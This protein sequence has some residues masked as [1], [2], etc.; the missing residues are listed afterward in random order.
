M[1]LHSKP[2]KR[3]IRRHD[4][5]SVSSE[6]WRAVLAMRVDPASDPLVALWAWKGW[7]L[8][9]RRNLPGEMHG[10][11]L[12]LPLPPF[13]GKRRISFHIQHEHIVSI[14]LPPSLNSVSQVAPR[15]WRPTLNRLA[16]LESRHSV[17]VRVFGSLA[18][19]VLTG[20]DYLT[21]DSD[22]DLLW[23]VHGDTDLDH[24]TADLAGIEAV[25]PMRLDGELVCEDGTAVNWREFH[26]GIK[27][28]L[29][30][31]VGGVALL[32]KT[33]FLPRK[34]PS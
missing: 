1:T 25:A 11:A 7:P 33:C 10:V 6:G 17:D 32:D 15:S 28:I 34:A 29:V 3:P 18:W 9:A 26:S 22:L 5:I 19:R 20:L 24:L 30:K 21:D 23:Q 4:L 13:A 8:I 27:E 14:T 16:G 2:S 31:T 12:G